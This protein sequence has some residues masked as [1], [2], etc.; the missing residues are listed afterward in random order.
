MLS[1]SKD[2][3][4]NTAEYYEAD[5]YYSEGGNA[6]SEWLGKGAEQAGLSGPIQTDDFNRAREGK[7]PD[8]SQARDPNGNRTP[9]WDITISAPKSVSIMAL[10]AGDKRLV[11]A[12]RDA[13]KTAITFVESQA[14]TRIRDGKQIKTERTGNLIIGRYTHD[15]S[16]AGDPQMHDHLYA[17]N[18]TWHAPT[19]SWRAVES[20]SIYAAKEAASRLYNA[21]LKE[22]I[23]KLGYKTTEM[24]KHGNF[25]IRGVDKALIETFSKRSETISE[26]AKD[27][28]NPNDRETRE[29]IA[30]LTRER[31]DVSKTPSERQAGWTAEAGNDMPALA[32]LHV[33]ARRA[34]HTTAPIMAAL[35]SARP[36]IAARAQDVLSPQSPHRSLTSRSM[37]AAR[38]ALQQ[39]IDHI[40]QHTAVPSESDLLATALQFAANT[41]ARVSDIMGSI[42]AGFSNGAFVQA[43]AYAPGNF[44]TRTALAAE[45]EIL[46]RMTDK[47]AT[48]TALEKANLRAYAEHTTL[49]QD[50]KAAFVTALGGTQRY[51][52]VV[53]YAGTG[54]SFL[55]QTMKDTVEKASPDGELMVIAPKHEQ[56][57][58][59]KTKLGAKADTV[60]HFL[61]ANRHI[62]KDT[63]AK[64]AEPPADN[65]RNVLVVDEAGMLSNTDTRN[66]VQ[67]ADKLGFGRVVMMGDPRQ[68]QSPEQGVPF[69]MGLK[70]GVTKI[71]MRDIRR[72]KSTHFLDAAKQAARGHTARALQT[73]A[74]HVHS[75]GSEKPMEQAAFEHWRSLDPSQRQDALIVATTLERRDRL[76][77]LIRDAKIS[78]GGLEAGER[79][80]ETPHQ[81]NTLISKRLTSAQSRMGKEVETGDVLIFH[82][83]IRGAG[84]ESGE[85]LR[86]QSK[87]EDGKSV[88]LTNEKGEAKTYAFPGLSVRHAHFEA[89]R[90]KELELREKEKLA[91]TRS[92][93]KSDIKAGTSMTIAKLDDKTITM[94]DEEGKESTFQRDDPRL[95]HLNYAYSSTSFAAQGQTRSV[96]I[97]VTGSKDRY[98]GD[99]AHTYVLLSRVGADKAENEHLAIYTD[100]AGKLIERYNRELPNV[101]SALLSTGNLGNNH[102]DASKPFAN[103]SK[104]DKDRGPGKLGVGNDIGG[105]STDAKTTIENQSSQ[106]AAERDKERHGDSGR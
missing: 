56:V 6:P 25:E 50:Q 58:E 76:N 36:T 61:A 13:T 35:Q 70:S 89:F 51:A 106:P 42:R 65:S 60:A 69:Q 94:R 54:K 40:G 95:R 103:N 72:Q 19:Q 101:D 37:G 2:S 105:Q 39:S 31:K 73:L 86:V 22:N 64:T 33:S 63:R 34:G 38:S 27:A 83:N 44:T 81:H 49:S 88:T 46:A 53:G 98:S 11:E 99:Q 80:G 43:Q 78:D 28:H 45:K 10:V 102:N 96:V 15:T 3:G 4:G 84:I 29:R 71:E 30:L 17:M 18:R 14:A 24:D 9:G 62:L 85:Q 104:Q 23:E 92:D 57:S 97:G 21:A 20:R 100:D 90:E 87:A 59:F 12:H 8:G 91:W 26:M 41:P 16:R 55:V 67:I 82:R 1:A 47:S 74:N 66:L 32:S 7:L 5:N 93:R 48:W 52:S 68:K 75:T 77:T 79:L